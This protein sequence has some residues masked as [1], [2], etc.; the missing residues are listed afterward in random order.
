MKKFKNLKLMLLG[1]LALGMGVAYALDPVGP[2]G[3]AIGEQ[4]TVGN[5]V[6]TVTKQALGQGN[7]VVANGTVEMTA[8]AEGGQTV[9]AD[10]NLIFDEDGVIEWTVGSKTYNFDITT[11]SSNVFRDNSYEARHAV[12]PASFTEIPTAAFNTLTN[13]YDLTF[14]EGSQVRKIGTQAFASTQISTFDFSPCTLLEGLQDGVFVQ[15]TTGDNNKN[16]NITT[17]ILPT[18]TAFKHINGAFQNL[19]KLTTITNLENSWIREL[20]D[21]AFKGCESLK[22]LNLPGNDLLYISKNALKGSAVEDLSINVGTGAT[23]GNPMRL[24]G[25]CTVDYAY[26]EVN[27]EYVYNYESDKAAAYA[28]AKEAAGKQTVN[29]EGSLVDATTNLYGFA[30]KDK[31]PLK[32]L[33]IAG[34]L[35]GKICKNAFGWCN[36]IADAAKATETLTPGFDVTGLNFGSKGQIETH[37]F[38]LCEKITS[39][40]LNDI[41]DNKLDAGEYTIEANA[42]EG[43]PIAD[44]TLG[45]IMT[46]NAI[47][48]AAFGNSLEHVTIG[49]VKAA[50]SAFEAYK[51]AVE[52][53]EAVEAAP[54]YYSFFSYADASCTQA[55]AK[56]KVTIE[57]TTIDNLYKVTVTDNSVDPDTWIGQV[58][59]VQFDG[60]DITQPG[61]TAMQLYGDADCQEP[62]GMYVKVKYHAAVEPQGA[63]EGTPKVPGAF[64]WANKSG[65]WLHLA[66][67]TG[68]YVSSDNP[69]AY[70]KIIPEG[71]FDFEA[72]VGP[73]FAAWPVVEIGEIKSQGGVFAKGA[74]LGVNVDKMT[75]KG[76]IN[77]NGLDKCILMPYVAETTVVTPVYATEDETWTAAEIAAMEGA[78]VSEPGSPA[79]G[80][81]YQTGD[82][83]YK[84]IVSVPEGWPD[85]DIEY[86]Q[87]DIVKDELAIDDEEATDEEEDVEGLWDK[88]AD[89]KYRKLVSRTTETTTINKNRLSELTFNGKIKTNGVGTGA[90]EKFQYLA[91]LQFTGLLSKAAIASGAFSESGKVNDDGT[92]GTDEVPFVT[93]TASLTGNDASE[94]P[95]ASDAFAPQG[96][97]RII[98]WSVSDATLSASIAN[99]IQKEFDGDQYIGPTVNPKFNVYKWVAI[100]PEEEEAVTAFIVFTDNKT[101][102]LD[103]NLDPTLAWGRYDLGSF[104]AE[105][106]VAGQN[107]TATNMV[108]PRHQETTGVG[109]T[110]KYKVLVTLYGMYWDQDP[111]GETASVYMVPLDAINGNYYIN[112]DNQHLIIA[113]VKNLEGEFAEDQILVKYTAPE[114]QTLNSVWEQLQKENLG[115]G[116]LAPTKRIFEKAT[117]SWT[118]EELVDAVQNEGGQ[119]NIG[120]ATDGVLLKDLHVLLDPSKNAGFDVKR[121]I[122]ERKTDGTGAFIGKGW[123]YTLLNNYHKPSTAARVI[124]LDAEQATAIFGVKEIKANTEGNNNNAIYNLQGVR[125]EKATKGIYI[126]NGKKIVVK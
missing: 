112:S 107:L 44:L 80:T 46:N 109:G 40:T 52:A 38:Y 99:A 20:V 88:C 25:G 111:V 59:Y 82:D 120:V 6:Y 63:E 93:Y 110:T 26:D 17:I 115:A 79:S 75:F 56:G 81:F 78:P 96:A 76:D 33:T 21:E 64:V 34:T 7:A 8:V 41:N 119:H 55:L 43:C 125:V 23:N 13:L 97:E 22:Q 92:I 126:Q 68:E 72:V 36:F 30:A 71:V 91:K 100:V 35:Q 61:N 51:A 105:G 117:Y 53:T 27:Q 114:E 89:G 15:T 49:T 58:F 28:A 104:A 5:Y 98:Y 67:G 45:N 54:A 94:N 70:N 2:V 95:F 73:D 4:I 10:N 60:D 87:V 31:T 32:K 122:I 124:W 9:D 83:E 85:N 101:I 62:T 24:L 108:I 121:M 12:I 69:D 42:F 50:D 37:S 18:S 74:I 106:K 39:L 77:T 19:T 1:L 11:M 57:V 123:Y 84:F 47:G 29:W 16:G 3:P 102:T 113:K 116:P 65:T 103:N 66:T 86:A 118:N 14:A 90:F 48:S